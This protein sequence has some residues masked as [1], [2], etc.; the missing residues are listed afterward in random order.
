[1]TVASSG[2][3][4]ILPVSDT[5]YSGMDVWP[6]LDALRSAVVTKPGPEFEVARELLQG[7]VAETGRRA[8]ALAGLHFDA[9][10]AWTVSYNDSLSAFRDTDEWCL[11]GVDTHNVDNLDIPSTALGIMHKVMRDGHPVTVHDVGAMP[12]AMRAL[13]TKLQLQGT[14]STIGV[15]MFFDGRL[16]GIMGLDMTRDYCRWDG[17]AVLALCRLAELFA[18]ATFGVSRE[19]APKH[20]ASIT[21]EEFIYFQGVRGIVGAGMHDILACS[22]ER[23]STRIYLSDDRNV[24]DNRSLK[25][26]ESVLPE[27]HFMR[28]HRS[29][30][31]QLRAVR[32]LQRRP[33]GQWIARIGDR[34]ATFGVSRDRVTVLR[35]RLGY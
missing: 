4:S 11:D 30:I 17:D 1:M 12:R 31:L 13:Q 5:T 33:T 15:P 28:V 16:R 20:A 6:T 10:R 21:H 8:L 2:N 34:D 19:P 23:D 32:E 14:K 22:A 27:S 25:W 3:G 29:S 7:P 26:W 9:D 35:N 24:L 18:A